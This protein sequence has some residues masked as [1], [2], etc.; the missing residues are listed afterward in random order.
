MRFLFDNG[1]RELKI[2]S[3]IAEDSLR[4]VKIAVNMLTGGLQSTSRWLQEPS[5][6]P[7]NTPGKR[8]SFKHL[9]EIDVVRSLA[10]SP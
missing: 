9:K 2:T 5:E 3:R 1:L 8:K 4:N 7:N 10:F 6:S